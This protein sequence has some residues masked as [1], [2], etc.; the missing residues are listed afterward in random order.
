MKREL[1]KTAWNLVKNLGLS[2]SEALK[3]AWKAFKLKSDMTTKAVYFQFVKK[4]GT[5]REA[6]GTLN[7]NVFDYKYKG[8][9]GNLSTIAYYDLDSKGFRC[10]KV[11]NLV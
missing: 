3:K 8:G 6:C 7:P 2:F 11:E 4:D 5:I 10:F 1:F 9:K